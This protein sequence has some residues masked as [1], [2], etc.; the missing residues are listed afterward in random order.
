MTRLDVAGLLSGAVLFFVFVKWT[1]ITWSIA[2]QIEL[3]WR[4]LP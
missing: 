3:L 2:R 4:W 1:E